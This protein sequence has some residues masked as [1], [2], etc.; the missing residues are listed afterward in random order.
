MAIEIASHCSIKEIRVFGLTRVCTVT[1]HT[2]A[3]RMPIIC[4]RLPG[5][6]A[7]V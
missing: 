5:A 7:G 4:D 1:I 6:C 3:E 2:V